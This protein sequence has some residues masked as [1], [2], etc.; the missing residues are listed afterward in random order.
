[1]KRAIICLLLVF[2]AG[3]VFA[4][5]GTPVGKKPA[6]QAA[7][8]PMT[9]AEKAEMAKLAKL[10]AASQAAR[11]AY[12][13]SAG[14]PTAAKAKK[15]AADTILKEADVVL[16]TPA[17]GPKDKYP[18]ALKLY[19]EVVRLDPKNKGAKDAIRTIEDIYKSMGRPVPKGG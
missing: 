3:S 18:K 8:K 17:L 16:V 7:K 15:N 1:M 12:E 13:R 2:T 4:Q 10:A 6:A 14:K 11:N 9:A 5:A 19:R